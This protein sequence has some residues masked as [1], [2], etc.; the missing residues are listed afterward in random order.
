MQF[1]EK[2]YRKKC[3]ELYKLNS[4]EFMLEFVL[5]SHYY[6]KQ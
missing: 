2:K 5:N 4:L 1:S 3:V 6:H